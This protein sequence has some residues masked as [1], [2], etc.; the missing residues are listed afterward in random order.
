MLKKIF[1]NNHIYI[2][3]FLILFAFVN[4]FPENFFFSGGDNWQIVNFENHFKK[5]SNTWVN[6]NNGYPNTLFGHNLFY[7]PFLWINKFIPL[8]SDIF[9]FL[10]HV[11]FNLTTFYSFYFLINTFK[12]SL[13]K[14][15]KIILS[16]IYSVNIFTYYLFWYSFSYTPYA[17]GYMFFP[18][19]F[20]IL[21]SVL[22]NSKNDSE[23]IKIFFLLPIFS[24]LS[25]ISYSNVA[26]YF[27]S[28]SI[29]SYVFI[30]KIIFCRKEFV[31][32]F[33]YFF[34]F[35]FIFTLFS[36]YSFF[37]GLISGLSLFFNP[38]TTTIFYDNFTWIK[39]SAT[40]FPDPLF[41]NDS[42]DIMNTTSPWSYF[43]IISFFLIFMAFYYSKKINSD[44]V[45]ILILILILLFI[46]NKGVN[47]L[48]E[49][50]INEIFGT[51][52]L[53]V[54]RSSDKSSGYLQ[55]FI[56]FVFVL[57]ILNLKNK[58]NQNILIYSFL[59]INV[60]SAYPLIFGGIKLHHDVNY[61]SS[62]QNYKNS[63]FTTIK[64]FPNDYLEISKYLAKSIDKKE[65]RVLILPYSVT[66]SQGWTDIKSMSHRGSNPLLML[67]D[68]ATIE[69]NVPTFKS[70]IW[71]EYIQQGNFENWK[72]NLIKLL[73]IDSIIIHKDVANY[74][75]AQAIA[76][77]NQLIERK[78]FSK[79]KETENLI[80]YKLNYPDLL[81]ERI[82]LPKVEVEDVS[83]FID[84][85]KVLNM[86]KVN[87]KI[88]LLVN[89]NESEN[90][91][92]DIPF[93][94][95]SSAFNINKYFYSK[96]DIILKD[97][98]KNFSLNYNKKNNAKFDVYVKN[99]NS[100]S[101]E[102]KITL[103]TTYSSFWIANCTNCNKNYKFNNIFLNYYNNTFVS[104]INPIDKEFHIEI[105]FFPEKFV[106]TI[107][108]AT[109]IFIFL[110]TIIYFKIR[111]KKI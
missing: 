53:T 72:L 100:L 99:N 10:F 29:F 105:Y 86:L 40:N 17:F 101:S 84:Y 41:I 67:S 1:K 32:K 47:L 43:S 83:T 28:L 39:N 78:L 44:Q 92:I 70:W 76:F 50:V 6:E 56:I 16:F 90:Y 93:S 42:I 30:L 5:W 27:C 71:G 52:I 12:N 26:F 104:K 62:K 66:S 13:S 85:I 111:V 15:H 23:K 102:L 37:P 51:N 38:E 88:R 9:A 3:F 64:K 46:M 77:V 108:Y 107:L 98:N 2:I 69:A 63:N 96:N 36:I 94:I 81:N 80:L 22:D 68:R 7:Y 58:K 95:V 25:S 110:L 19:L 24:F 54:F 65:N 87:E 11:F 74:R 61:S 31:K 57:I 35:C 73:Q 49:E 79:I 59:F 45:I 18:L 4:K 33:C 21:W 97:I 106:K 91:K 8:R 75:S 60:I 34:S 48:N 20:A 82:Y 55:F 14:K 103:N 89:F 109:L